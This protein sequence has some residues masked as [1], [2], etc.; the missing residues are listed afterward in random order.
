MALTWLCFWSSWTGRMWNNCLEGWNAI[1]IIWREKNSVKLILRSKTSKSPTQRG[2]FAS[3]NNNTI[4]E[5][6][7]RLT[8]KSSSRKEIENWTQKIRFQKHILKVL[9][10]FCFL[11][12]K[13]K[14][15]KNVLFEF[16]FLAR[17]FKYFKRYLKKLFYFNFDFWRENSNILKDISK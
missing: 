2:C 12:R 14:Y 13:F 9:F 7:S 10:E 3:W 6:C 4:K 15:F 5:L 8:I 1:I 17:K 11:A 16:W